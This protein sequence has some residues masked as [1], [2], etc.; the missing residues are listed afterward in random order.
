MPTQQTLHTN[1]TSSSEERAW[2]ESEAPGLPRRDGRPGAMGLLLSP[3]SSLAY[4]LVC[5]VVALVLCARGGARRDTFGAPPAPQGSPPPPKPPLRR[6]VRPPGRPDSPAPVPT[7]GGEISGP[8][9][10]SYAF[11]QDVPRPEHRKRGPAPSRCRTPLC[12]SPL[13]RADDVLPQATL[14]PHRRPPPAAEPPFLLQGAVHLQHCRLGHVQRP[15]R[16]PHGDRDPVLSQ[17]SP[18]QVGVH[19]PRSDRETRITNRRIR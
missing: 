14:L 13:L 12:A 6:V 15:R 17:A 3:C 1:E 11:S 8:Q 19:Q 4:G 18:P 2:E 16:P 10:R 9:N 7:P 5:F